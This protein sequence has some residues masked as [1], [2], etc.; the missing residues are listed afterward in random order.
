MIG[1]SEGTELMTPSRNLTQQNILAARQRDEDRETRMR[2][3]KTNLLNALARLAMAR[4]PAVARTT[5]GGPREAISE[6]EDEGGSH[7]VNPREG[8]H[9]AKPVIPEGGT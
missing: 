8:V 1:T 6:T 5:T 9:P 4:T 7:S 3:A 2:K